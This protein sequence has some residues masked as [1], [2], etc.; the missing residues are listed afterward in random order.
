MLRRCRRMGS[1][2]KLL[3]LHLDMVC[4]VCL[5]YLVYLVGSFNQTDETDRIDQIEPG[6]L[7]FSGRAT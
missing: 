2:P 3:M 1:H 7:K 4:S 6:Y 5:V